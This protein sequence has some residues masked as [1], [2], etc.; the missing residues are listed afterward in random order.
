MTTDTTPVRN[1]PG[2]S[3]HVVRARKLLVGG[4]IGGLVATV[5]ALIIFTALDGVKGLLSAGLAAAMVLFFYVVGQLLIMLFANADAKTL[6]M[7][8]MTSYTF[9]VIILGAILLT[10]SRH[11]TSWTAIEPMAVFLTTVLVVVGWLTSEVLT[12]RRLR[13]SAYDTEYV[14]PG[15]GSGDDHEQGADA[16][17]SSGTSREGG[18]R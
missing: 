14:G 11:R 13:I 6:L 18:Q 9:R 3:V 5:L 1:Q 10:V 17:A 15:E 8:S 12:F 16:N 2:P 4:L 7:V